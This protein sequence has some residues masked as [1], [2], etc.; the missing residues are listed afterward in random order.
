MIGFNLLC[1]AQKYHRFQNFLPL[2]FRQY[3]ALCPGMCP[4]SRCRFL[5][6]PYQK[7]AAGIAAS[8]ASSVSAVTMVSR[9]SVTSLASGQ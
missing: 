9:C 4:L 7:I 3:L 8:L 6:N 1:I 5:F 2:S